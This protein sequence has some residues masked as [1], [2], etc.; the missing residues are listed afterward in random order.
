MLKSD[1]ITGPEAR[2]CPGDRQILMFCQSQMFFADCC[3]VADFQ[4]LIA[5]AQ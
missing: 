5:T 2:I 4:D 3:G 1:L